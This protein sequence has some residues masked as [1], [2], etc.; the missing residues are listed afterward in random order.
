MNTPPGRSHARIRPKRAACSSRGT[1]VRSR[2]R[3]PRRGSP[4]RRRASSCRPE[5]TSRRARS[6]GRRPICVAE[7][8]T[9]GQAATVGERR[10]HRH[11]GA[12]AELED[13]G[14]GRDQR[15]RE[16]EGPTPRRRR[17]ERAPREI[18]LGDP[19]VAGGDDPL[20]VEACASSASHWPLDSRGLPDEQLDRV[21][22]RRRRS[23]RRRAPAPAPRAR[24]GGTARRGRTRGRRRSGS[25]TAGERTWQ[26]TIAQN[27]SSASSVAIVRRSRSSGS[28]S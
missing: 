3:R 21:D 8:S 11:P 22:R 6:G 15:V 4:G 7:M 9:P 27:T 23:G 17:S 14:A 25:G 5:G 1:W 26:W 19:V 24:R 12:A 10:G 13:V 20:R 18:S 2:R 16:I 28:I